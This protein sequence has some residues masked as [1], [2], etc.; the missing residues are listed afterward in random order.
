MKH[1]EGVLSLGLLNRADERGK[2]EQIRKQVLLMVGGGGFSQGLMWPLVCV[3]VCE[4]VN[5]GSGGGGRIDLKHFGWDYFEIAVHN[6]HNQKQRQT[7]RIY[8]R[9]CSVTPY[10]NLQHITLVVQYCTFAEVLLGS[11]QSINLMSKIASSDVTV[12]QQNEKRGN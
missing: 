8:K 9:F 4:W 11:F 5:K 3:C 7:L 12:R 6:L 10:C 1:T 2:C